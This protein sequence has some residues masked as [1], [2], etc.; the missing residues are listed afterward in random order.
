LASA[1]R[2]RPTND[3]IKEPRAT[4]AN[5][6]SAP[7]EQRHGEELLDPQEPGQRRGRDRR[8]QGGAAEVGRDQDRPARP[9]V[10]PDAGDQAER[11]RG[12]ELGRGQEAHLRGRGAERERRDERQRERGD[13]RAEQ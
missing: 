5:R 2:S 7:G 4:S 10:D 12:R 8:E 6:P 1:S 3:G 11:D 13:L 9:A